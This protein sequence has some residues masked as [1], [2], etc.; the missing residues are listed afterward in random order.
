M[1]FVQAS[2]INRKT[3]YILADPPNAASMEV[4]P[5]EDILVSGTKFEM[6]CDIDSSLRRELEYTFTVG[7]I[8]FAKGKSS[9]KTILRSI[10][11]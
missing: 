3:T 7:D 11:F 9:K 8:I 4:D 1:K 2:P 6:S 5:E 10:D